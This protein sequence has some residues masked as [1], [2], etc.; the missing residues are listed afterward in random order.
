[1]GY[2]PEKGVEQYLPKKKK[3]RRPRLRVQGIMNYDK[4]KWRK[5]SIG[6]RKRHP[7]C[8]KCDRFAS[9]VDHIESTEDGGD[10]WSP[11]N[12]QSLCKQCH[13]K[14]T[15]REQMRPKK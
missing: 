9:D 11:D 2:L 8:V 5:Y 15:K 6:Y 1:M 13:G 4:V 7:F 14:K 12:H 3:E 10:I